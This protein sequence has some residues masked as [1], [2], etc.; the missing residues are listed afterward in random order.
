MS[1][2]LSSH[3]AETESKASRAS[4]YIV[5]D[6][7]QHVTSSNGNYSL[8]NKPILSDFDVWE[9]KLNATFKKCDEGGYYFNSESFQNDCYIRI[10]SN[11]YNWVE[12]S[13]DPTIGISAWR[14]AAS[15]A[16]RGNYIAFGHWVE[17]LKVFQDKFDKLDKDNLTNNKLYT[18]EDLFDAELRQVVTQLTNEREKP[19]LF[20]HDKKMNELLNKQKEL[21]NK[22]AE[23]RSKN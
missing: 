18:E 7:K 21:Q 22:I 4:K 19:S 9:N 1:I 11:Y 8:N 10:M 6:L 20:G 5:E 13:K 23:I 12:A 17:Q 14:A 15:G 16:L 2:S 3:A